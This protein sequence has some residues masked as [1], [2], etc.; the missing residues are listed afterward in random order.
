MDSALRHPPRTMLCIMLVACGLLI[1]GCNTRLAKVVRADPSDAHGFIEVAGRANGIDVIRDGRRLDPRTPLALRSGDQVRTGP[2]TGAVIRFANGGEAVL[3]PDTHVRLGSLEVFFGR[4]LADLR[5]LFDVEDDTMVASVEGTR[6]M[7]EKQRGR[8][9]RVAVLEGQVRCVP[10]N[11]SWEP[12]RLAA[13]QALDTHRGSNRQPRVEPISGA[14][15]RD[16]ERWST[17]IRD[18]AQAGFCCAHGKVYASRSDQC[19]G[20]FERD[21]GRA[22]AQCERGW[23][24]RDGKVSAAIRADCRYGF[25][26]R[27][28]SAERAC[29][30]PPRPSAT[31][32]GWCCIRGKLLQT[33]DRYCNSEQGQFYNDAEQARNRC[34]PI[35]R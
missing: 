35:I 13:G 14:E 4:V 5:G 12:I 21:E 30:R 17:G 19:H 8:R 25:H 28:A 7:F 20:L 26:D 23:C 24:C 27:R 6:F 1:G 32:Q 22:R 34:R 3:A 9:T 2:D 15:I 33:D 29:A 10:K 18:A 11:G 31:A 16:I